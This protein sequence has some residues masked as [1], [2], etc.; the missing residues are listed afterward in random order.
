VDKVKCVYDYIKERYPDKEKQ[1]SENLKQYVEGEGCLDLLPENMIL[2]G[3]FFNCD[4]KDCIVIPSN[5]V[6]HSEGGCSG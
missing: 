2:L 3:E 4:V 1:L 6:E 5:D